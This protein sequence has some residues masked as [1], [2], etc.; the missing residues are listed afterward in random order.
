[1][2]KFIFDKKDCEYMLWGNLS[3]TRRIVTSR[4]L[5]PV[6]RKGMWW[7]WWGGGRGVGLRV[8]AWVIESL[9]LF[10]NAHEG[11]ASYRPVLFK[12]RI[13]AA[14]SYEKKA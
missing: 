13:L 12:F 2:G 14:A 10:G 11:H 1:M 5:Y 6:F 3:S 4:T 9:S 7:W 8:Y